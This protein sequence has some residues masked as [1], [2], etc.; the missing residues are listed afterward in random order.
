MPAIKI[1]GEIYILIYDTSLYLHFVN[2]TGM[3][4]E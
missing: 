2:S 4:G 3:T 1:G